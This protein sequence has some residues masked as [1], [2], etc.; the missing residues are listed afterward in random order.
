MAAMTLALLVAGCTTEPPSGTPPTA[1]PPTTA[2]VASL[3]RTSPEA[4]ATAE[5]E[6]ELSP[7]SVAAVDALVDR[8]AARIYDPINHIDPALI[9]AVGELDDE[10]LAWVIADGL[11]FVGRGEELDALVMAGSELGGLE[12]EP[13]TAWLELNNH[14]I[15]LD[16]PPPPGYERWKREIYVAVDA[17][18]APFFDDENAQVDWRLVTF[19]GV[20]AD[21]RPFGSDETCQCIAALDDPPAEPADQIDWLVDGDPVIGL[22]VNGE[23]RAYPLHIMEQHELVNDVLGGER[24]SLAYCTLCGS[25]QAYRLDA[26]PTR[27]KP[28]DGEAAVLRTSGLL[29]RSNKLMFDLTSRSLVETFTGEAWTGPWHEDG[30]VLEQLPT[31]TSQWG[32]WQADH[33]TTT[34]M[35]GR[36]GTGADYPL[37]PLGQRD[38]GG[39]IFPVGEI[40]PRLFP[41]TQVVGVTTADGDHLAFPVLDARTELEGEA[42]VELDEVRLSLDGSG[43][44]AT[45]RDGRELVVHQAYWFAWSQFHPDTQLWAP[46]P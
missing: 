29:Y 41:Q 35:T 6:S 30:I 26:L 43:L 20:L 39:P 38:D 45:D 10:R 21:R 13:S 16:R 11:R 4:S 8:L 33:P 9:R 37:D 5:P 12:L 17:T 25:G 14:L 46:T 7:E 18:W 24:I 32:A 31:V 22:V 36:N 27:F 42:S 40:D 34:L 44:R 28:P 3:D 15:A 23:A 1:I 19:G 2:A